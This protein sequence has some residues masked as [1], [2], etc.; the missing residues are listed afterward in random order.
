MDDACGE[1]GSEEGGVLAEGDRRAGFRS[2]NMP[3]ACSIRLRN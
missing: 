3:M 1:T 2:T